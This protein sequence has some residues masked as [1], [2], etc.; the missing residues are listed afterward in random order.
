VRKDVSIKIVQIKQS[1]SLFIIRIIS[2]SIFIV[3][4][5]LKDKNFDLEDDAEG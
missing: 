4:L 2:E 3:I 1:V 5:F